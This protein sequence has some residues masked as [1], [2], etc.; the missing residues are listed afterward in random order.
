MSQSNP[1]R[2]RRPRPRPQ[3]APEPGD[4]QPPQVPDAQKSPAQREAEGIKTATFTWRGVELTVPADPQ[5]W[6]PV[7]VWVPLSNQNI[8]ATV[9]ALLGAMQLAKISLNVEDFAVSDYYGIFD[10]IAK[11]TGFKLPG[12]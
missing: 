1:N 12:N 3:G 2:R 4:Y 11:A 10:A 9:A 5:E 7:S 8:V 6:H